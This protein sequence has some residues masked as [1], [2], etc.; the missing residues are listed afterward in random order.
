M[1]SS[2]HIAQPS[3]FR[4]IIRFIG[5]SRRTAVEIE[6]DPQNDLPRAWLISGV[7]GRPALVLCRVDTWTVF[8]EHT[9]FGLSFAVKPDSSAREAIRVT[10]DK[11]G[12][13]VFAVESA[14]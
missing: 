14:L 5:H 9:V 10:A 7:R 3:H 6:H 2:V 11:S 13:T 1:I 8:G 4:A 12:L